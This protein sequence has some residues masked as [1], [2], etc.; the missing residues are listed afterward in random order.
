L[1]RL[2]STTQYQKR[3]LFVDKCLSNA[4]FTFPQ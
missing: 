2:T 4:H 1:N 3:L